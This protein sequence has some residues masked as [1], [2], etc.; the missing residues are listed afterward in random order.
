MDV[1]SK[2]IANDAAHSF[3]NMLMKYQNML[4][5]LCNRYSTRELTV[6]DLMQDVAVALW[7]Q[8]ER[9][10]NIP[11]GVQRKS[12]VWKVA[13]N[14]AVDTLRKTPSNLSLEESGVE[15]LP[16]EDR[17]LIDSLYEQIALLD[18]PDRSLARLQMEG[19]SYAEIAAKLS[20]SEKNVSVRLVRIKEKLRERMNARY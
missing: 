16:A 10:W 17:S 6:E 13:R 18:E 5:R 14:A 20:M 9:L 4:Y 11:D 19:Y 8:R 2:P 15:A 12:W 3:E 1:Q 7:R